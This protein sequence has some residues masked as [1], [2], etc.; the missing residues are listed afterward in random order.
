MRIEDLLLKEFNHAVWQSNSDL[1]EV[2]HHFDRST[3]RWPIPTGPPNSGSH[4]QRPGA[5]TTTNAL[6][7]AVNAAYSTS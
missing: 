5:I 3:Y 6:A 1:S 4:P 7:E 2:V